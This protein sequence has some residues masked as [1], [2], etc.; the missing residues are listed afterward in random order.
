MSSLA[1]SDGRELVGAFGM[2]LDVWVWY[3]PADAA[4][5]RPPPEALIL[6]LRLR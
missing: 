3:R 2:T 6:P 4:S 1:C 5:R